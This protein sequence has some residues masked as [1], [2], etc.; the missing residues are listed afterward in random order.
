MPDIHPSAWVA[1]SAQIFGAVA[2]SEHASIWHNA[3]LRAE[4]QEIRVGRLTNVQD[5]VMIHVPY[6][7]PTLVGAFTNHALWVVIHEA[8]HNLIFK[9]P[10]AN[11]LA[12]I[13]ANRARRRTPH[14][15]Y[16]FQRRGKPIRY[17]RKQW[18]GACEQAL[19]EHRIPHDL[20]RSAIKRMVEAGADQTTIMAWSG[21]KTDT[22]FRRYMIVDDRGMR[23][24][25]EKVNRMELERS[26]R[27]GK[28]P[29]S[30]A[31]VLRPIKWS[32]GQ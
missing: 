12:G 4:C 30:G 11:T 29:P 27:E 31:Q 18:D 15:D 10:G 17:F 3:V 7:R 24:V 9:T 32:K 22:V 8:T 14:C 26:R 28:R 1:P 2:V 20:R 5:F 19:G 16:V 13:I 25:V 23:E 21:H 6:D